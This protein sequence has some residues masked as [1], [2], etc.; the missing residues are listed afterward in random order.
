[1]QQLRNALC[2]DA[3]LLDCHSFP[4]EMGDVDICIGFNEDWAKPAKDT[5]EL[6]VNLFT[7]SKKHVYTLR[8]LS[9]FGTFRRV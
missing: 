1:V 2:E 7:Y 6:A 8:N 4:S 5:L 3:L 9:N